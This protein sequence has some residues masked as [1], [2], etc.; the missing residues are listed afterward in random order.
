M[1]EAKKKRYTKD[2][3]LH[4]YQL[5]M[6]KDLWKRMVEAAEIDGRNIRHFILDAVRT[7]VEQI[8]MTKITRPWVPSGLRR[9]KG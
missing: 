3:N 5:T 8:E 1:T 4:Y 2:P 6:P 9:P 7:K